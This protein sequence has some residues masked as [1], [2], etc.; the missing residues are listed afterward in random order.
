MQPVAAGSQIRGIKQ[1]EA[2]PAV[3][4]VLGE[5]THQGLGEQCQHQGVQAV[6]VVIAALLGFANELLNEQGRGHPHGMR[7]C[8]ESEDVDIEYDLVVPADFTGNSILL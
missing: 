6:G 2:S 7:E 4:E 1:R 5:F 3:G 8:G